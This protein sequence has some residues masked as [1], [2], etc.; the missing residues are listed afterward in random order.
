MINQIK[1]Q[2]LYTKKKTSVNL[3][4][5]EQSNKTPV[6]KAVLFYINL[7]EKHQSVWMPVKSCLILQEIIFSFLLC[8]NINLKK[9]KILPARL[10]GRGRFRR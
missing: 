10:S 8:N 3:S 9:K 1:Y 6:K 2:E 4:E 7:R 5:N